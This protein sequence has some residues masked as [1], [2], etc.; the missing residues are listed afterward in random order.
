M[1]AARI[2]AAKSASLKHIVTYPIS[3]GELINLVAFVTTRGGY[4]T[5]YPGKWV[6]EVSPEEMRKCYAGWEPEVQEILNV[7]RSGCSV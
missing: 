5:T 6:R 4:G 2:E 3:R 1:N 7:S